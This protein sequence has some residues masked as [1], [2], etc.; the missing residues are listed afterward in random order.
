IP[1]RGIAPAT[2]DLV[3]GQLQLITGSVPALMPF[4]KDGRLK[5]LAVTSRKRISIAPE[6]PGM[7]EQGFKGFDVNNYWGLMAPPKNV[8]C[9]HDAAE[10]RG[11][12][13]AH[14]AR[15]HCSSASRCD[16]AECDD[17][18]IYQCVFNCGYCEMAPPGANSQTEAGCLKRL[19]SRRSCTLMHRSM[20][21]VI[22]Q[23]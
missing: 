20:G 9:D 8:C 14:S 17:T 15:H 5:A 2:L 19:E 1:Y 7:E 12:Q 6:I 16:R 13:I 21:A 11:Q 22:M 18:C 23:T 3:G 10:R 4:I